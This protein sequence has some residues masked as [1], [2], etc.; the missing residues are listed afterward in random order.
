MKDRTRVIE[1]LEA[2]LHARGA[3]FVIGG[4]LD[5]EI[6]ESFLRDA[7]AFEDEPTTTIRQELAAR[8]EEVS[9]DLWLLIAQLARLGIVIECTDHLDDD[10]LLAFLLDYADEP[11]YIPMD[12]ATVM[13]VDI[14]G[15]GSEEDHALY[16]RYYAAAEDREFWS[17][18]FPDE[19][20]PPSERPPFDRDRFLPTAEDVRRR[21]RHDP[22]L[23]RPS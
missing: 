22:A 21:R 12:D 1:E 4:D 23:R 7:L 20:L 8:G 14:L 10:A 5:E 6:R 18:E 13:H 3:S 19:A 2:E 17:E 15:S 11:D 9:R 16:L